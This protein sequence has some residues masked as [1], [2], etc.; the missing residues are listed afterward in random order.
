MTRL[1]NIQRK[2]ARRAAGLELIFPWPAGV[3]PP[4]GL[5]RDDEEDCDPVRDAAEWRAARQLID[6]IARQEPDDLEIRAVRRAMLFRPVNLAIDPAAVA[7]HLCVE[8]VVP[9]FFAARPRGGERPKPAW[10]GPVVRIERDVASAGSEAVSAPVAE[11]GAAA[12]RPPT[13][14]EDSTTSGGRNTVPDPVDDPRPW[15]EVWAGWLVARGL[16]HVDQE[17]LLGIDPRTSRQW[18]SGQ[19][20]PRPERPLRL[21]LALLDRHT[22]PTR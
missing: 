3:R 9:A 12:M 22:I 4:A 17:R 5:E 7:P 10:V 16:T 8:V 21:L 1:S 11:D 15:A 18:A 13:P 6:D 14:V 19:R 2:A 20:V